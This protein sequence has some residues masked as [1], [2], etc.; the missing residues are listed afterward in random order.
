ML[1]PKR[2]DTVRQGGNL[3]VQAPNV[4][5]DQISTIKQ[6]LQGRMWLFVTHAT[7]IAEALQT[8]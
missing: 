5:F 1:C 7:E 3:F 4:I 6:R 8:A 2:S